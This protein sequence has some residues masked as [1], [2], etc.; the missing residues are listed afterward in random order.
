MNYNE[1]IEAQPSNTCFEYSEQPNK[2]KDLLSE[3]KFEYQI[4]GIKKYF[5]D[6]KEE[7]LTLNIFLT[8]SKCT[9]KFTFGMSICDTEIFQ[10][11]QKSPGHPINLGES[12]FAIKQKKKVLFDDIVYSVLSSVGLDYCSP[13]DFQEFCDEYGYSDDSIKAKNTWEGCLKQR[14][15]LERIFI[16]TEIEC[17]PS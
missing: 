13:I 17:L 14:S 10:L 7:R 4:A 16:D 15:K 6:D 8:R 11:K 1:R 9:I 3:I 5:Q 12:L 2:L